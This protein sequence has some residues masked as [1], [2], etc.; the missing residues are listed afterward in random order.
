MFLDKT[1]PNS[2]P[3]VKNLLNRPLA[4][5]R[6]ERS[7]DS[8]ISWCCIHVSES[9]RSWLTSG[10]CKS[11]VKLKSMIPGFPTGLYQ[12]KCLLTFYPFTRMV[13]LAICPI[14]KLPA[15]QHFLFVS[16][17]NGVSYTCAAHVATTLK[18]IYFLI[19]LSSVFDLFWFW[20]N[21]LS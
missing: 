19:S 21:F 18:V 10:H 2:I 3:K 1:L 14:N 9:D 4:L 16:S 5:L 11:N 15:V 8:T 7:I 12:S 6:L 20:N 17:P 13:V